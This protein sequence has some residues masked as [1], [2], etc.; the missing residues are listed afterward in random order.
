MGVDALFTT[1]RHFG[2][3]MDIHRLTICVRKFKVSERILTEFS[4]I[5]SQAICVSKWFF[6]RIKTQEVDMIYSMSN[7]FAGKVEKGPGE[8]SQKYERFSVI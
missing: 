6:T 1:E 5:N 2:W 7:F 4:I 8:F 3:E